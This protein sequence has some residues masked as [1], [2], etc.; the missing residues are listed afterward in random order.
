MPSIDSR[1][2]DLPSQY[3]RVNSPAP[4]TPNLSAN[5]ELQP[6]LN[7]NLRCPLPPIFAATDNQRQFYRGGQTPQ[8][9]TLPASPINPQ[10]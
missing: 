8:F 6:G 2:V 3:Q 10:T 1:T 5:N 4:P 7:T 9:R